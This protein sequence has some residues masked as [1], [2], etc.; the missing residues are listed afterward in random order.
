M[1][2]LLQSPTPSQG[3]CRVLELARF[4]EERSWSIQTRI[5]YDEQPHWWTH[6]PGVLRC[7]GSIYIL[8]SILEDA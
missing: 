7:A 3:L 4:G 8:R 6:G 5:L 1:P 2:P